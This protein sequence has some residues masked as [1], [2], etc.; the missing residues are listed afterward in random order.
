MKIT[1]EYIE[2]EQKKLLI[3]FIFGIISCVFCF[4]GL[5]LKNWYALFFFIIATLTSVV[6]IQL[7][8]AKAVKIIFLISLEDDSFFVYNKR[9]YRQDLVDSINFYESILNTSL[10]MSIAA[11]IVGF[12]FIL[13]EII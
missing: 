11:G 10:P 7:L 4:G 3:S 13:K 5:L 1:D 9:E 6:S 12:V 8:K 2:I